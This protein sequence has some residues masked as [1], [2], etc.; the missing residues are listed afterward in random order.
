[1]THNFVAIDFRFAKEPETYVKR[2]DGYDLGREASLGQ[3]VK[4]NWPNNVEFSMSQDFPNR[5]VLTDLVSNPGEW[6]LASEKLVDAISGSVSDELEILPIKIR[7]HKKK[8]VK[9][10]Y[11]FV[12]PLHSVDC[13]DQEKSELEWEDDDEIED[14]EKLHI[15]EK[16]I[17]KD[18]DILRVKFYS[19]LTLVRRSIF[20][21]WVKQ[22][23]T[24]LG[25]EEWSEYT[26]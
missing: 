23:F 19:Y 26:T 24:G 1:M 9:E 21:E 8:L 2:T 22:G 6:I 14:I 7:D 18:R 10:I 17:P 20:D 4:K 25:A 3:S 12:N 11:F 16:K 5:T 13:I 15:D